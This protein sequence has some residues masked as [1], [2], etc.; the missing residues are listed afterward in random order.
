MP[1]HGTLDVFS[2][3]PQALLGN[4]EMKVVMILALT[5]SD[6]GREGRRCLS[7]T[8]S[9]YSKINNMRN[10]QTNKQTDR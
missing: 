2:A 4:T 1:V 9:V 8:G 3:L 5:R 7:V 6:I 10:K